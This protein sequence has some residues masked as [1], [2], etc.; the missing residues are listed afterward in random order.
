[1][2]NLPNSKAL[3]DMNPMQKNKAVA[4]TTLYLVDIWGNTVRMVTEA[5]QTQMNARN[6]KYIVEPDVRRGSPWD[7]Y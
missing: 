7:K 5:S 4:M 3:M 6:V 1:M 2:V